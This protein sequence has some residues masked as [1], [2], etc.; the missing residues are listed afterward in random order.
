MSSVVWNTEPRY[1]IT[2]RSCTEATRWDPGNFCRSIHFLSCVEKV[3]CH[4][5]MEPQCDFPIVEKRTDLG[6]DRPLIYLLKVTCT[7]FKLSLD[8][9]TGRVLSQADSCLRE[10]NNLK[11]IF[12]GMGNLVKCPAK[13]YS[14]N[15]S[16]FN[17]I[18]SNVDYVVFR[19]MWK[20][21]NALRL[22][23]SVPNSS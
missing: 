11:S 18:N 3:R 10:K 4:A 20:V 14:I 5:S 2:W 7:A 1:L 6:Q 21:I 9:S 15:F 8:F 22:A 12:G 17:K 19:V 16:E 23:N 13:T